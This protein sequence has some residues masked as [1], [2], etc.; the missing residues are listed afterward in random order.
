MRPEVDLGLPDGVAA[1]ESVTAR[2]RAVST[3]APPAERLSRIAALVP[4][5][6]FEWDFVSGEA[7]YS[8]RFIELAGQGLPLAG[9]FGAFQDCIHP[10][11]VLR[12][13]QAL[14]RHL[15]E[16]EPLDVQFSVAGCRAGSRLRLRGEAERDAAGRPL[17]VAG[18]LSDVSRQQRALDETKR[19][20]GLMRRAL[21]GI[22]ASVAVLDA[23]GHIVEINDS[24]RDGSGERALYGLRF[25][26]GDDY[27]AALAKAAGRVPAAAQAA[28]GVGAVLRGAQDR[29]GMTYEATDAG[30]PR[31]VRL[32]ARAVGDGAQRVVV[33]THRELPDPDADGVPASRLESL[34][35]LILEAVPVQIAYVR[36]DGEFIFGNAAYERWFG[37][38]SS[39]IEGRRL[40]DIV[41]AADYAQ[42]EPRVEAVLAGRE[43]E[44][45]VSAP[46]AGGGQRELAV[47]YLPH[48]GAGGDVEGFF[49]V[50]RDVTNERRLEA[51][52]RLAQ[53]MEAIGRLTGGIAHDFN[54]L[55]NVIIGNL[56]LLERPLAREPRLKRNAGTALRAALRGADL[57]RRLLAF[58]RQQRLEPRVVKVDVRL[59]DMRELIA[60]TLGRSIRVESRLEATWPIRVDPGQLEDALL[61]LA[62]NARDAM[63]EGGTLTL[64]ARDVQVA[65]DPPGLAPGDYVEVAVADTGTGMSEDV[66]RHAFEPFFTTKQSGKGTGL[67]LAMVYGFAQQSGGTAVLRSADGEGTTVALYFPRASIEEAGR[68]EPGAG[69]TVSAGV[70]PRGNEVVLLVDGEADLRATTRAVLAG[71]GYRVLEAASAADALRWIE[72][73]QPIDLLFSDFALPGG[74]PGTELVRRARALRPGLQ[75]LLA[76]GFTDTAVLDKAFAEG[77]ADVLSK[78][79]SIDDLAREVRELLDREK[80]DD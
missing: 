19:A 76:S 48:R 42:I 75:V 10:E 39:A 18:T 43:V 38:P 1:G 34:Y 26:F 77:V 54:N 63:P 40:Q 45:E 46:H 56:Q 55:L 29:F 44:F 47:A 41:S 37:L 72:R 16:R 21:D 65:G 59:E 8:D 5:G 51:G 60:R 22:D 20:E 17:R 4:D 9:S 35:E 2:L 13:L 27:G 52:L 67:G 61:N 15:E 32:R 80:T 62:I 30:V 49:S 57:T 78:P 64:S 6:L 25:G 74:V 50:V 14:R 31:R 53:K 23:G 58:S 3:A 12:V 36:R 11:D 71:L 33:V 68:A 7:W 70:L 73:E 28:Q 69:A 79:Y 24:W 66:A